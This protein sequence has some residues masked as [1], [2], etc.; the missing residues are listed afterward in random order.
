M[1]TKRHRVGRIGLEHGLD[2]LPG[3]PRFSQTITAVQAAID[4]QGVVIAPAS[5]V[6]DDLAAGRLIKPFADIS[7]IPTDYAWCVVS[8]ES[9]A[10]NTTVVAFRD[11]V[12]R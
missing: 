1:K 7:D 6:K 10:D 8:P 3:D 12:F 2:C 5:T 9:S 4:A 11:S